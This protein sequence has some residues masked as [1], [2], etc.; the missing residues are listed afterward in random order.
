MHKEIG[1]VN[2]FRG[3]IFKL[4]RF[5]SISFHSFFLL[6][7]IVNLDRNILLRCDRG[8]WRNQVRQKLDFVGNFFDSSHFRCRNNQ[9]R[10]NCCNCNPAV[11][12]TKLL[13]LFLLGCDKISYNV[14]HFSLTSALSCISCILRSLPIVL[15]KHFMMP[16]SCR[17]PMFVQTL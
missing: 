2:R 7:R 9:I 3:T 12:V 11:N 10:A 16:H 17:L 8:H 5:Y 14:C 13:F 6:L 4:S 1:H 15:V